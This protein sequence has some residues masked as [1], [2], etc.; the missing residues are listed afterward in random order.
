ML[1]NL[2]ANLK[3]PSFTHLNFFSTKNLKN[4]HTVYIQVLK[5]EKEEKIENRRKSFTLVDRLERYNVTKLS[6]S[7][8]TSFILLI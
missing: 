8:N 4:D 5:Q 1:K 2:A 7:R 6:S 3:V